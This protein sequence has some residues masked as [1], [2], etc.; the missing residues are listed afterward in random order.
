MPTTLNQ[1][2]SV[3]TSD[4]TTT[5]PASTTFTVGGTAG[6]NGTYGLLRF[7]TSSIPAD[8]KPVVAYVELTVQAGVTP[9]AGLS[10]WAAEFGAS[11]DN[12]DYSRVWNNKARVPLKPITLPTIAVTAGQ[13]IRVQIPTVYIGMGAGA[14]SDILL[15]ATNVGNPG[16]GS[17]VVFHGPTAANTADR[18]V[19][20]V[21][22]LAAAEADDPNVLSQY[23]RCL[24]MGES[25]KV[26]AFGIQSSRDRLV[27]PNRVFQ[28]LNTS[29]DMNAQ[30][31][32]SGASNRARTMPTAVA[33]GKAMP[34]GS[35]S[36]EVDPGYWLP[37]LLSMMEIYETTDLGLVANE[38]GGTTQTFRHRFRF[39]NECSYRRLTLYQQMGFQDEIYGNVAVG[40]VSVDFPEN[41]FV[42]L[43]ADVMATYAARYDPEGRGA[44]SEYLL[45][46]GLLTSHPFGTFTD[47][48]ISTTVNGQ[49]NSSDRVTS[50]GITITRGLEAVHGQN[51]K[52][53]PSDIATG[54]PMIGFNM[55]S[56]FSSDTL[57][58]AYAGVSRQTSPYACENDVI[59]LAVLVD[60]IG[61]LGPNVQ[62]I[63]FNMPRVNFTVSTVN[64]QDNATIRITGNGQAVVDPTMNSGMEIEVLCEHP[65]SFFDPAPQRL[66]VLPVDNQRLDLIE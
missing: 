61:P 36:T 13:K 37:F 48:Q 4:G 32:T 3:S 45:D 7:N 35:F 54:K 10:A 21:E 6:T 65:A 40:T 59:N 26:L 2:A 43:N 25:R 55:E 38:K 64:R 30:S 56:Y 52:R 18:P 62:R 63:R 58:R 46:P 8:A 41:G 49:A 60:L 17:A 11:L 33:P 24:Q 22:Y 29:L 57:M 12:A 23:G 19:L 51:R 28:V 14:N 1:V 34:G 39:T 27:R 66:T 16:A 53:H 5:S 15:L 9:T 50:S 47:R 31:L 42:T 44:D 20:V